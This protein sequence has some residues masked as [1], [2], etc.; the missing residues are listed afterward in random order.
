MQFIWGMLWVVIGSQL[1]L[2]QATGL[3]QCEG[4]EKYSCSVL[5]QGKTAPQSEATTKY[6]KGRLKGKHIYEIKERENEIK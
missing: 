2:C 1:I 3:M 4:E 6:S 5:L